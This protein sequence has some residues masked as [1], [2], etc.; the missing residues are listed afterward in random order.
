MRVRPTDVAWGPQISAYTS[1]MFSGECPY[2]KFLE[3][4]T[5]ITWIRLLFP[6]SQSNLEAYLCQLFI[7]MPGQ[8]LLPKGLQDI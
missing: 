2:C 7:V 4:W 1:S 5:R 6:V 3:W 8:D